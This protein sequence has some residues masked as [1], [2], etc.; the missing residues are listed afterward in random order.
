MHPLVLIKHILPRDLCLFGFG[1]WVLDL[2]RIILLL[3]LIVIIIF[4][5]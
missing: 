5:E 3:E 1:Y 4:A 2:V